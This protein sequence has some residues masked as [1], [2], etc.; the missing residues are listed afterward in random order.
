MSTDRPQIK[1]LEHLRRV[2]A[3]ALDD[4]SYRQ[5]LLGDPAG[6]LRQEGITVPEEVQVT[7]HQ[8]TAEHVHLVLPTEVK[9]EHQL[10]ADETKVTTLTTTLHF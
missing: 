1:G 4:A 2:A 6:V 9:D 7:V 8:N 5:Q 10:S 3:K